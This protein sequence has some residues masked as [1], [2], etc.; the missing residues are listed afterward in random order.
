[1]AVYDGVPSIRLEGDEERALALVPEAKALLYKVQSFLKR[2]EVGTFAM[3]RRVSDDSYI[4]AL[5]AEGQN[6]LHISVMPGAVDTLEDKDEEFPGTVFP[7]FYSG[8]VFN[9]IQDEKESTDENGEVVRTEEI[10]AELRG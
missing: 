8:L 4:Y 5:S 1:M 6:L 2:A 9:G 7:D 3:T 10:P